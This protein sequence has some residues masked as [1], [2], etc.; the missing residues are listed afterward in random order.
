MKKNINHSVTYSYKSEVPATE[1]HY[2]ILDKIIGKNWETEP[3]SEITIVPG[4]NSWANSMDASPIEIDRVL[5]ILTK[6]KKEGSN[7]VE[8]MYHCDHAGYY[9]N[10]I[11][12]HRSTDEE[13]AQEKKRL[14]EFETAKKQAEIQ[15]LERK[16]DQ[17][18]KSLNK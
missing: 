5:K 7:Y 16:I 12:I 2:D 8:I 17:I 1:I 10:G 6:L 11:D 14:E 18:K 3:H 4:K 15:F 9:F 13:V